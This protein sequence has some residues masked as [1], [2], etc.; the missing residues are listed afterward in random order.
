MVNNTGW[1]NSYGQTKE[2]NSLLI[3]VPL[4]EWGNPQKKKCKLFFSP[5][6]PHVPYG[7]RGLPSRLRP[8]CNRLLRL[9]YPWGAV[10]LSR[11]GGWWY[12]N[13]QGGALN[14]NSTKLPRPWGSSP[15]RK[16]PHGRTGNRTRDLMISSQKLWPLDHEAGQ[17]ASCFSRVP[18]WQPP[19]NGSSFFFTK[20]MHHGR[21]QWH[22]SHSCVI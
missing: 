22:I 5:T 17:S 9:G 1:N 16:N 21:L 7:L 15:S 4:Q 3:T 14:L 6:P 2:S 12:M 8:K 11:W 10:T 18:N 19:V 20:L 13:Y